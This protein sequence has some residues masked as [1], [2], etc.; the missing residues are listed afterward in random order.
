MMDLVNESLQNKVV[1]DENGSMVKQC[2]EYIV[3]S[4]QMIYEIKYLIIFSE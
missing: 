1:T 2:S 3:L 4:T